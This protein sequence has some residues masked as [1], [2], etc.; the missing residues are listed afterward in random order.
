[1]NGFTLKNGIALSLIVVISIAFQIFIIG[2]LPNYAAFI[3]VLFSISIIILFIYRDYIHDN[4]VLLLLIFFLPLLYLNNEFHYSFTLE[5]INT[6]PLILLVILALA[7]FL[8]KENEWVIT[9]SYVQLPILI[10]VLYYSVSGL[11]S[12]SKGENTIWIVYQLYHVVLYLLIFPIMYLVDSRKKY[13]IILFFLFIMGVIVSLEYILFN[14]IIFNRRFVT[15]QSGFLPLIVSILFSFLLIDKNTIHRILAFLLLILIILGSVLT[16]TRTLWITIFLTF[17]IVLFFYY[18]SRKKLNLIK[19]IFLTLTLLAPIFFIGDKRKEI[20]PDDEQTQFVKYRT[21]SISNPLED[22]SLLQRVEFAVYAIQRFLENPIFGKGPGDYLKY[23]L[24][25]S[26][27]A[28][29]YYMDSTWLYVLWKTGIVGLM[30]Y[31]WIYFRFC[32]ATYFVLINTKNKYTKILSLGLIAGFIGLGFLGLLSPLLIKYK[33]NVLIV[34]LFAYV[35]F[36]RRSLV[37][38]NST[39]T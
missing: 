5:L 30:L 38:E 9:I 31:L 16:L 17:F 13:N 32:K 10:F 34:F 12:L 25:S 20:N 19:V 33:T 14:Q 29:H 39:V 28:P 21:E 6:A 27:K 15:F 23:K 4:S 11:I 35:E 7:S 26:M 2:K 8:V 37:Q 24:F 22:T 1:V 36:E 18:L 3:L